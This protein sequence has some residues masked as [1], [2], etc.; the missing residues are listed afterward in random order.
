MSRS[1]DE[2]P[3]MAYF[4]GSCRSSDERP[5]I[6]EIPALVGRRAQYDP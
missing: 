5:T 4:L 3:V 6:E 2:Q 1:M